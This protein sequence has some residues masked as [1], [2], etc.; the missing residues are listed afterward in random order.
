[1][2]FS[3][4]AIPE[5]VAHNK[6]GLLCDEGNIEALAKNIKRLLENST[7]RN[8]LGS[9]GIQHVKKYFDLTTQNHKLE[10]LYD[11]ILRNHNGTI[12]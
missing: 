7:L 9:A 6:T 5:V 3:S 11:D 8:K 1:V 10:T 2:A 4:G 12:P